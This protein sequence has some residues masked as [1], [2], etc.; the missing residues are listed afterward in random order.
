M[1][2]PAPLE[3]PG[4]LPPS[5]AIAFFFVRARTF[6]AKPSQSFA[7]APTCDNDSFLS[8][9]GAPTFDKTLSTKLVGAPAYDIDSFLHHVDASTFDPKLS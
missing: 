9:Q 2:T 7:G 1:K 5:L 3:R 4:Q 8:H 6:D